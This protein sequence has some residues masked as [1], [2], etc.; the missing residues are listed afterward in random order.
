MR[1]KSTFILLLTLLY[2][3]AIIA[4]SG[5]ETN[6][7]EPVPK[8]LTLKELQSDFDLLRQSIIEAHG[9][10]YRFTDSLTLNRK[11]DQYRANLDTV[12]SKLAFISLV[13]AMVA[14]PGDGRMRLEYDNATT[15]Q[16]VKARMFPFRVMLTDNRLIVVY[17]E[18]KEDIT[19]APGME[20]VSIN[21]H[22]ISRLIELLLTKISGDGYIETGKRRKLERN[23]PQ[24]YWLF[25]DQSDDFTVT[26]KD[27]SG[28]AIITKV[29]G[30]P[31]SE[32]IANR[33]TNTINQKMLTAMA[34]LDGSKGNFSLTFP[35]GT[36]IANLRIR[37][38][39]D[40]RF[41]SELDS[42]FSLINTKKP[43]ALIV[44]LRGNGGGVDEYGAALV[45]HFT[46]KP[47]RYF[48]RIWIRSIAPSFATWKPQTFEDLRQGTLRDVKGGYLVKPALHSGV[49]EQ[50]PVAK[51]YTG[52]LIV[53]IDGGTFSTSADVVAI[54]GE[55]NQPI[56]I[57]EETAGAREGNTS[58]LNALIKLPYSG[59]SLKIQMYGYWNALKT[60]NKGRGTLPTYTVVNSIT[61]LLN[62]RD[63]Q[64]ERALM[65]GRTH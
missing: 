9:S 24:Y 65:L 19:I 61:D 11:F 30:V 49:G 29:S 15:A 62:S 12:H 48:D 43:T 21:G 60:Q 1:K 47:F 8:A 39:D 63:R 28:Q 55:V 18:T 58:G 64:W 17:N 59:L 53:L 5:Q 14:E 23:F 52:K 34:K 35:E 25:A 31:A 27:A 46:D 7:T 45:S 3:Q 20:I 38:F 26:T 42:L 6:K 2:C 44:D 57:G 16:S 22:K 51:P 36:S 33:N 56:F 50:Q 37:T 4:Q 10:L 54:L 13:S 32:R 41:M 40:S